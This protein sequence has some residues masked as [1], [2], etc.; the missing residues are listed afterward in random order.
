[1]RRVFY[2]AQYLKENKLATECTRVQVKAEKTQKPARLVDL[3]I[4]VDV[5]VALDEQHRKGV[6]EAVHDGLI[7]NT[8]LQPTPIALSVNSSV[9][10]GL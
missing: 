5:P 7:H 3:G 8:S 1:L 6:E 2:A 4:V 9:L 10:A